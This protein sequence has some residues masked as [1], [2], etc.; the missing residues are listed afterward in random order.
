MLKSTLIEMRKVDICAPKMM[1]FGN[2]EQGFIVLVD[3]YTET[4]GTVI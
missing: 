3:N 2:I 4:T 1:M